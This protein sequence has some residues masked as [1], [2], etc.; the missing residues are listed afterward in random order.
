M[1]HLPTSTHD[2]SRFLMQPMD[3]SMHVH[4]PPLLKQTEATLR[5]Q[6]LNIIYGGG[7]GT[8]LLLPPVVHPTSSRCSSATAACCL[9]RSR[10]LAQP[11]S[12]KHS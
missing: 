10:I 1:T 3:V 11:Q 12:S 5:S 9:I 8:A 2:S 4:V 6:Q 7:G